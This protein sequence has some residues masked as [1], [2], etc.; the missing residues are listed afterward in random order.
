MTQAEWQ[1]MAARQAATNARLGL[2]TE[3]Q[4]NLYSRSKPRSQNMMKK[5]VG[6]S[7]FESGQFNPESG[8]SGLMRGSS[9]RNRKLQADASGYGSDDEGDSSDFGPNFNEDSEFNPRGGNGLSQAASGDFPGAQDADGFSGFEGSQN[10]G[11]SGYE[12]GAYDG[13]G[14]MPKSSYRAPH[15]LGLDESSL[16]Y[17]PTS[18]S[19]NSADEGRSSFASEGADDEGEGDE[20]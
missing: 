3:A 16:Q 1:K 17:G 15:N 20:D 11:M 2:D 13:I 19:S 18:G 8:L 14:L 9:E 7:G 4:N 6:G 5:R 10:D 12:G